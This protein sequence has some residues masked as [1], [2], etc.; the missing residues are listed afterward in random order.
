MENADSRTLYTRTINDRKPS[1]EVAERAMEELELESEEES[2]SEDE[3]LDLGLDYDIEED[4]NSDSPFTI[5][6]NSESEI[7]PSGTS[8]NG[9]EQSSSAI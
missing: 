5:N 6:S 3:C 9:A 4:K 1:R 2:C 7:P 8:N